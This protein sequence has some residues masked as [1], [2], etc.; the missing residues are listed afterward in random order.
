GRTGEGTRRSASRAGRSGASSRAGSPE[1]EGA[2]F[3]ETFKV[4]AQLRSELQV[5][6]CLYLV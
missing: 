3:D 5:Y 2:V 6:E 4:I 1:Q